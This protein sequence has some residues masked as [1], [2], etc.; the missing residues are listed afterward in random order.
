LMV[1]DGLGHGPLAAQASLDAVRV[2]REHA[3]RGPGEILERVHPA[4]RATRGAA[5]GIAEVDFSG[6]SLRFAGV[7]NIAATIFANGTSRSTVSQNGTVGHTMRRI[8][9]FDYPFPSGALLVMHSDGLAT[10]W[11]LGRYAGLEARHPA[12]IAAVLYRDFTRERD[13]V[14][15]LAARESEE[16]PR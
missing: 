11:Q 8:Q 14:T 15:V 3:T 7:G 5:I 1:A 16:H 4:L 10:H 6:R 13:D 12:L 9:E 2:F